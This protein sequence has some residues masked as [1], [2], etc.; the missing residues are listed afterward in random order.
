M[1]R[2]I[3][4]VGIAAIALAAFVPRSANAVDLTPNGTSDHATAEVEVAQQL[5]SEEKI[6][7]IGDDGVARTVVTEDNGAGGKNALSNELKLASGDR[8]EISPD[9][10]VVSVYQKG[11]SLLGEFVSPSV[12]INGEDV[13][14]Q[15]EFEDGNL[16]TTFHDNVELPFGCWQGTT[17]KWTWRVA[18]GMVCGALGVVSVPGGFACGLGAAGAEDAMNIDQRAC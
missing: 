18:A 17:A 15:F 2:S 7:A 9:G 16:L 8:V 6:L 14:G 4:L 1:R 5:P 3:S 13:Q 12:N 11:G 10:L